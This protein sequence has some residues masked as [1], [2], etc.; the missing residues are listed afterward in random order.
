MC[1]SQP[2]ISG[3]PPSPRLGHVSALLQYNRTVL[4][5][6]GGYGGPDGHTKYN[7]LTLLHFDTMTWSR[8]IVTGTTPPGTNATQY[9]KVPLC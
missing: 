2:I 9:L 5:I 7:D 4:A 6:F 8:P 3:Q 1:W